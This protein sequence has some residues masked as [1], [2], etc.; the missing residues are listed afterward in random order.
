MTSFSY[1]RRYNGL[2]QAAI[3]DWAGTTIDFGSRAPAQVFR[4]IFTREGIEI[5]ERQAREP[6]GLSKREHIAAILAM[7]QVAALWQRVKG[8]PSTRTDV[9]SLYERFLPLQREVLGMHIDVI[10]GTESAVTWMRGRGIKCG[11]TTGFTQALMEVVIPAA[12]AGGY[13]PDV[14][15]CADDVPQGRPSPWMIFE[16]AKRLNVFP[17]ESVVA[18]DDTLVGIEAGLNA[19]CWTVA[20]IA[21][22]NEMGLSEEQLRG[23]PQDD[24]ERSMVRIRG[25]F[26]RGGAHLAIES[27][28]DLPTAI[29]TIESWI[30]SGRRP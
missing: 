9:D 7:P 15:I 25:H 24:R 23:L 28:A 6:M 12:R 5:T 1:Q 8:R 16:A 22:G 14:V 11:S 18:V 13:A 21:T 10:P 30:Q 20:V 4:E 17:M 3:M 26:L 29:E 27:V 2:I 19:G